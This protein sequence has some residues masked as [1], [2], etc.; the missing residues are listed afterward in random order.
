M[1]HFEKLDKKSL[2]DEYAYLMR[3][4]KKNKMNTYININLEDFS[5]PPMLLQPYIENAIWHGLRYKKEKGKLEISIQKKDEETVVISIIDDGI[6]RKKS[7]EIKTKNQLKQKSK[8][9]STIKNRIAILN[10]MYKERV[11][12][13]ISDVLENGEGTKVTLLLKKR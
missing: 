11:I 2:A 13:D 8:G 7:Q 9:M 3:K 12:V 10:D 6:G 5:I 4:D 1:E